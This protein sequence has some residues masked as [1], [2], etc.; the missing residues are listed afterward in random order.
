M[1]RVHIL[2]HSVRHPRVKN[3]YIVGAYSTAEKARKAYK[4]A[5]D[6]IT[7]ESASEGT[8]VKGHELLGGYYRLDTK[9]D[10]HFFYIKVRELQ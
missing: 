2:V 1:K 4:K 8:F 9:D 3:F 7:K 6:E 10:I 5:I